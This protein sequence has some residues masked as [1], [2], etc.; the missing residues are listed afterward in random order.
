MVSSRALDGAGRA[1]RGRLGVALPLLLAGLFVVLAWSQGLCTQDD[2]FISFRYAR[3][4]AEGHGLV[5]NPGERVEGYT[6]FLWTVAMAGVIRAGG[7]PVLASRVL[8]IAFGAGL[9][10]VTWVLAGR[11]CGRSPWSSRCIA[12][13]LL[14]VSPPLIAEA[15][16]GLETAMFAFLVLL[17]CQRCLVELERDARLP[18]WAL[19]FVLA[20]LTRPEGTLTF[21]LMC[22]CCVLMRWRQPGLV[23]FLLRSGVAFAVPFG[24]YFAWRYRYY[25]YPFPNT[26]YAKTGGGWEQ[27]AAGADY[28]RAFLANLWWIPVPFYA[29]AWL[30]V[31][32]PGTLFPLALTTVYA[33]YV[34]SVGGD[35]KE[36]FRFFVPIL[37]PLWIVVASGGAALLERLSAGHRASCA[38]AAGVFVVGAALVIPFRFDDTW[39]FI[40]RRRSGMADPTRVE[41]ATWLAEHT[42]PDE[43]LVVATAGFLPYYSSVRVIDM[44]GLTDLVI[45]RSPDAGEGW[46]GHLRSNPGYLVERRPLYFLMTPRRG[47]ARVRPRQLGRLEVERQVL[48]LPSFRK[49]YELV[50]P[51]LGD[52]FLHIFRR[53][54]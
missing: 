24:V 29:A 21:A 12:P 2:S 1:S 38:R 30:R 46:S 32:S 35:Y 7:D 34:V 40:E 41:V 47:P 16:M 25:G 50:Q 28:L 39:A 33:A 49:H 53:K 36:S 51:P 44:W 3:N 8:G 15:A 13:L 43:Y 26:Y 14:A 11:A 4:L 45:A 10:L 27:V 6:N 37:A 20:A 22:G 54:D 48:A 9:V 19:V 17:G 31:R 42:P 5:F 18:A 23:A 52:G